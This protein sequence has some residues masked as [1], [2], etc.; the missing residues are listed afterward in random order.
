MG[1]AQGRKTSL[2]LR[3]V[4]EEHSTNKSRDSFLAADLDGRRVVFRRQ[5][6]DGMRL[7]WY[8]FRNPI[9]YCGRA[10]VAKGQRKGQ[11]VM[12]VEEG[13]WDQLRKPEATHEGAFGYDFERVEVP[14][15]GKWWAVWKFPW[16]LN[17]IQGFKRIEDP[18]PVGEYPM[19]VDGWWE[20]GV[21]ESKRMPLGEKVE[22]MR[23]DTSPSVHFLRGKEREVAMIGSNYFIE[24]Y[25]ET[26]VDTEKLK[27]MILA[28]ER[29]GID[30]FPCYGQHHAIVLYTGMSRGKRFLMTP[31]RL[32]RVMKESSMRRGIVDA[33]AVG[34]R[35][36][37]RDLEKWAENYA[38]VFSGG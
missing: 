3:H 35:D 17:R 9:Y 32:A 10:R 29:I 20:A 26:R 5:S 27:R 8:V 1:L 7:P 24:G 36:K 28:L 15:E 33:L 22:K 6:E 12:L 23:V 38:V 31:K 2:F 13:D 16:D 18:V 21:K 4:L 37:K 30:A 25:W 11:P 34:A 19:K 14:K